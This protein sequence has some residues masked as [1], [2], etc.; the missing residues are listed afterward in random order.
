MGSGVGAGTAR[1]AAGWR[2][3]AGRWD[4]EAKSGS[5]IDL[6]MGW[7]CLPWKRT[8]QLTCSPPATGT[9]HD[10]PLLLLLLQ[11]KTSWPRGEGR[12]NKCQFT[13]GP[14]SRLLHPTSTWKPSRRWSTLPLPLP[15]SL[16]LAARVRVRVRVPWSRYRVATICF[17]I[18]ISRLVRPERLTQRPSWR[19]MLPDL[20]VQFRICAGLGHPHGV[21]PRRVRRLRSAG[22][23][24]APASAVASACV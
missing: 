9:R 1:Q 8:S 13:L 2:Q 22:K 5:G 17:C 10:C 12:N 11:H 14:A 6:D 24:P 19:R 16:P 23:P 21:P 7:T 4:P 18:R 20:A 3:D 15:L